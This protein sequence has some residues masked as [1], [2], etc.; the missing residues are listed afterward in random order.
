MACLIQG[1][2]LFEQG[3]EEEGISIIKESYEAWG[4]TGAEIFCSFWIAFLAEAS[5][6]LGEVTTGLSLLD[7]T[8]NG[9]NTNEETFY[10]AEL[11]RLKGELSASSPDNQSQAEVYIRKA[12]DIAR[13]QNAKSLELKST[14]SLCHFLKEH[15]R[16]NEELDS[17]SKIYN[18]FTEGFDT[19]DLI[20]ARLL[21]ETLSTN[22]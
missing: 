15:N 6:R 3:K 14:I 5:L 7:R 11:Y 10:N 2:A 17:L 22:T 12:I 8:L 16:E 13:K 9:E 19:T 21:L 4:D 18:W 1:W 20:K